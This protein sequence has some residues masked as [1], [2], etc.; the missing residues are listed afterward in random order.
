M[1]RLFSSAVGM[2]LRDY[3]G[4]LKQRRTL[5]LLCS[6]RSLTEVALAAGFSD[7]P[8][9]SRSF[10]RWY[11]QSPSFSRDPKQVHVVAAHPARPADRG[12]RST[13]QRGG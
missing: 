13:L 9:F 8:Q 3:Q 6:S 4:W 1:A 2:S 7:S 12:S 10:Q 11:G 5:E